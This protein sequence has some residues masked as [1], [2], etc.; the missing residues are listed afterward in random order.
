ME[1][2]RLG[3]QGLI[4]S[5]QGLGCMGMSEFYGHADEAESI[6]TIHRALEIGI[7]FLDTADMYGHGANERLVGRA[8]SGQR[9]RAVLATKFGIVR[10]E[11]PNERAIS[12]RPEYVREACE[13]SLRRLGVDTIDLYYQHRVDPEVPIE[14][15]VG[16][17]GELVAAG[18]VR[19]LG[20]SEAAPE[21]IRRAH[22]AHPIT[23][24]QSEL[25]LWTRDPLDDVLPTCTRRATT[26][27]RSPARGAASA[28]RR[29]RPRRR[30]SSRRPSSRSSTASRRPREIA[31]PT[32]RRSTASLRRPCLSS[33]WS[34]SAPPAASAST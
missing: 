6:G 20:L 12:G 2:R 8:I 7:T 13:H 5:A 19:Y 28:S 30:S 25:S 18:K 23:A 3:S 11:D 1:Q 17:M 31:T 21:T 15:T 24:L 34:S 26:S 22:A 4:V 32:C 16:A 33:R 9:E 29:T 27:C 10:G 14:E